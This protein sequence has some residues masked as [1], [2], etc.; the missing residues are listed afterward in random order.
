MSTPNW[1]RSDNFIIPLTNRTHI[2]AKE[3]FNKLDENLAAGIADTAIHDLYTVFHP[4]NVTYDTSFAAWNALKTSNPGKTLDVQQ[5]VEELITN[6]GNWDVAIQGVHNR[7]SAAYKSLFSKHR[8]PFQSGT[9]ASRIIALE[10]L[11]AGIGTD[12]ALAT[13]KAEIVTFLAGFK[14]ARTKQSG[15]ITT[16]DTALTALDEAT[17][18]AAE[19]MFYVYGGLVMRFF[20]TPKSMEDFMPVALLQDSFQTTFVATLKT[21]KPRRINK[22]KLDPAETN[23]KF[24]SVGPDI[25]HAYYTT[26]LVKIPGAGDPFVVI[27]PNSTDTFNP[28][29][30]GYTDDKRCLFVM[31]MGTGKTVIT[32][33]FI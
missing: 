24:T 10:A 15:Q 14:T 11:I 20:Q 31:N 27:N 25:L 12:A 17:L 23:L 1:I 16:I 32:I 29:D 6:I 21:N 26:G 33:K 3:I 13:V 30:L 4:F 8:T 7:S 18:A 28:T 22:R 2:T 9:V 19:K 5:N